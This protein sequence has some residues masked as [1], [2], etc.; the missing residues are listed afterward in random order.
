MTPQPLCKDS[1]DAGTRAWTDFKSR[2]RLL[3]S[4]NAYG[5]SLPAC[6]TPAARKAFLFDE[7]PLLAEPRLRLVRGLV[8]PS[9]GKVTAGRSSNP[10][11]VISAIS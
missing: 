7:S 9:I 10:S 6:R 2:I 3:D 4:L 1:N 11:G 5:D 8:R